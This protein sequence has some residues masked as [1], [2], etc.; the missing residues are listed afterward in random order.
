MVNSNSLEN[1]NTIQHNY[2]LF[3]KQN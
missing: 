3:T 1:N 2:S